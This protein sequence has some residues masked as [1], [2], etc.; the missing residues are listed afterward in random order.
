MV[1]GG[2]KMMKY[3]AVGTQTFDLVALLGGPMWHFL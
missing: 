2:T 3:H 1:Q